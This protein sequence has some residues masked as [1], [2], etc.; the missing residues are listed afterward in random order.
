M[1]ELVWEAGLLPDYCTWSIRWPSLSGYATPLISSRM[2]SFD[3]ASPLI[4]SFPSVELRSP[5]WTGTPPYPTQTPT[6]IWTPTRQYFI[7]NLSSAPLSTKD[8]AKM[9]VRSLFFGLLYLCVFPIYSSSIRVS[10]HIHLPVFY[11]A[12]VVG[13]AFKDGHN[14]D[15]RNTALLL[16]L[17]CPHHYGRLPWSMFGRI[18]FSG[19]LWSFRSYFFV[20]PAASFL[21]SS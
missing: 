8:T 17:I 3:D 4:A 13:S 14:K 18:S 12:P 7:K 6:L 10:M 1:K 20:L 11:C 21:P 9:A 16:N 5:P 19:V 15:G 2:H